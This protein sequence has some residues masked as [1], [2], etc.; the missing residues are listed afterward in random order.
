ME[1][2]T[3]LRSLQN[4]RT[5]ASLLFGRS[6]LALRLPAKSDNGPSHFGRGLKHA[7]EGDRSRALPAIGG[8]FL[9]PTEHHLIPFHCTDNFM[10]AEFSGVGAAQLLTSLFENER[11]VEGPAM[12]CCPLNGDSP[13]PGDIGGIGPSAIRY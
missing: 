5:T 2:R 13:R 1:E 9:L 12:L 7:V 3:R 10:L 6:P 4:S 11:G 8:G